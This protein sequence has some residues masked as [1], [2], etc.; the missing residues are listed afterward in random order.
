MPRDGESG[1]RDG[2]RLDRAMRDEPTQILGRDSVDVLLGPQ[3]RNSVK[4]IEFGREGMLQQ[5]SVDPLVRIQRP[6]SLPQR[7]GGLAGGELLGPELDTDRGRCLSLLLQ[8]ETERGSSGAMDT[9]QMRWPS[10]WERLE[11]RPGRCIDPVGDGLS[12]QSV[13]HTSPARGFVGDR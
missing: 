13:G 1:Q 3:R 11:Q 9:D 7:G 6:H 8:V 2:R 12:V 10:S 4:K 5:D